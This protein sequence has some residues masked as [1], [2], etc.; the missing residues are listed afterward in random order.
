M[1]RILAALLILITILSVGCGA[2]KNDFN[3]IY[4]R[5]KESETDFEGYKTVLEDFNGGY[6]VKESTDEK[7]ITILATIP[8][9]EVN[10]LYASADYSIIPLPDNKANS[11][12]LTY[13]INDNKKISLDVLEEEIG[14]QL[15]E[16]FPKIKK[17]DVIRGGKVFREYLLETEEMKIIAVS[18][19]DLDIFTVAIQKNMNED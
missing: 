18:Y 15:K 7:N 12:K 8:L 2:K 16:A 4:D 5:M 6:N 19:Q 11:I 13:T 1:K 17:D 9:V 10:G 14:K 3:T